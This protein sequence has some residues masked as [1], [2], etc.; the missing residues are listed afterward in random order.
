MFAAKVMP[1]RVAKLLFFI[2]LAKY[3]SQKRAKYPLIGTRFPQNGKLFIGVVQFRS[4][5]QLLVCQ[6]Q[7]TIDLL[8]RH[9]PI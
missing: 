7:L 3:F 4:K 8:Q 2:E 5:M 1:K 6:A 9:A